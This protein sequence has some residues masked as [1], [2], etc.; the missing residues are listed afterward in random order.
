VNNPIKPT[1]HNKGAAKVKVPP[2][3]VAIEKKL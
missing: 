2:H 1:A 3:M